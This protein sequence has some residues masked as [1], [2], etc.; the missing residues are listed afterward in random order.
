MTIW[1]SE[2]STQ[3]KNTKVNLAKNA[4][5]HVFLFY[6]DDKVYDFDLSIASWK[7]VEVET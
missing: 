4:S 2:R 3:L 5:H 7:N 1:T 6:N